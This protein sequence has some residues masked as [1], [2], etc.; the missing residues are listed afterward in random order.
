MSN[1]SS[2]TLN[3][4]ALK[5]PKVSNNEKLLEDGLSSHHDTDLDESDVGKEE[6]NVFTK[7]LGLPTISIETVY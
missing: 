4:E 5:S 3:S 1:G 2:L 7:L 6:N